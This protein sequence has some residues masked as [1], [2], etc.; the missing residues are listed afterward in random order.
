MI[1]HTRKQYARAWK[2]WRLACAIRAA[3]RRMGYGHNGPAKV[4][5]DE[6]RTLLAR[7]RRAHV[8]QL[9]SNHRARQAWRERTIG[10]LETVYSLP[11]G[12]LPRPVRTDFKG[13]LRDAH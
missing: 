5:Y 1:E 7:A 13:T 8:R 11:A 12:L 6:C 4:W 2:A 9:A 3:T 10:A